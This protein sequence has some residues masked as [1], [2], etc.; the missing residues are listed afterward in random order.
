MD[1]VDNY[2]GSKTH[3]FILSQL[4]LEN[5]IR[6]VNKGV[7]DKTFFKTSCT[8]NDRRNY[9]ESK[10]DDLK[11]VLNPYLAFDADNS[12]KNCCYQ[13]TFEPFV[14]SRMSG[15]FK[16]HKLELPIDI[17]KEI[18]MRPIVSMVNCMGTNLSSWLLKKLELI[19][20]SVSKF[21]IKNSFTVFNRIEGMCLDA[22]FVLATMDFY[23][24]FT[25]IPFGKVKHITVKALYKKHSM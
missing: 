22:D 12:C 18:P 19:A 25:N 14:I 1:S 21:K 17:S 3:R 20:K 8:F 23:N 15:L 24:M 13:L 9:V 7:N 16:M 5:M 2:Q 10:Y 11:N 4:Y 6:F